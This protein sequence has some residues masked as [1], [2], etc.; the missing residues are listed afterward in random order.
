MVGRT[1]A[2]IVAIRPL[3]D[4]VI[5]DY[6][7]T[8][9]MIKYFI[10]KASKNSLIK[11]RVVICVPS[12]V[13]EV[14][15]M[16]V[17][18]AAK[19]AGAKFV[20][21]IE[22]PKAAAIGAGID[23]AK[24]DGNIILDIGGGTSDVAVLSLGDVV[25]SS[26]VKVAGD[27]FDDSIIKYVKKEHNVL[28]GE[29]TA[30]QLKVEIGSVY[31]FEEEKEMVVK[32]RDLISGLPKSITLNS[33]DIRE[34]FLECANLIINTLHNVLERTPPELV[35]DIYNNGICMTGGGSLISGFDKLVS[36]K[37]G[38]K[39]Y[40]ANDAVSCVSIGTGKSLDYLDKK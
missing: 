20:A 34:P 8:E 22:E 19:H 7:T 39:A 9:K 4:G 15:E 36:E 30:E 40:V 10:T 32:G 35:G 37:T 13:T 14:E 25:L 5:S 29:R 12:G 28:I 17:T 2:N 11:P 23:I 26:S 24:P 18:D 21:L 38:I 3:K 33:K 27:K 1:P 16:A 31:P 6:I